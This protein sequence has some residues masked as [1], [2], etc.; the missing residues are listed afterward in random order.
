[1]NRNFLKAKDL[2]IIRNGVIGSSIEEKPRLFHVYAGNS[3]APYVEISAESST[4]LTSVIPNPINSLDCS[5]YFA[6]ADFYGSSVQWVHSLASFPKLSQKEQL[7]EN[8]IERSL[9]EL[10]KDYVYAIRIRNRLLD[11]VVSPDELEEG[12]ESVSLGSIKY[13]IGFIKAYK[14]KYPDIVITMRGNVK[15]E[16]RENNNKLFTIDFFP[17][18]DCKFLCFLPNPNN[19]KKVDRIGGQA[20]TDTVMNYANDFGINQLIINE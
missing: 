16:W 9:N 14:P 10:Q 5:E 13:F 18:G 17:N 6:S 4:S 8:E 20:T 11:L 1:M 2:E 15:A 19:Q 7:L 3:I 12:E